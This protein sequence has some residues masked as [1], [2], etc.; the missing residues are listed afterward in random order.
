MKKLGT[1][2]VLALAGLFLVV[3]S[4]ILPITGLLYLLGRL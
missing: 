1:V 4:I 3:W 2:V